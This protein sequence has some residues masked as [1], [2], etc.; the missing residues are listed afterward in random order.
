MAAV[1]DQT[2]GLARAR[3]A[4]IDDLLTLACQAIED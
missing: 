2:R 3:P 1:L 4:R